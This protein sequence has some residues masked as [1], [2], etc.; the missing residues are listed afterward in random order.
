MA[1]PSRRLDV[2][3]TPRGGNSLRYW[4]SAKNP[5]G[6]AYNFLLIQASR[7]VPSLRL[8]RFLLRL[9]GMK[10]GRGAAIGQMATFDFFFPEKI[11]LGEDCIIGFGATILAHEFLM[12]E[13]RTGSTTVGRGALV[14]ANSTVLAGVSIG[15]GA[16]VSAMTL[17]NR[18]VPNGY[19]AQGVP[20]RLQKKRAGRH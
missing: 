11:S 4:T 17:V 15:D 20:C 10:V 9:T 7:I 3:K 1:A 2:V 8:K 5:A 19:F 6:V 12:N 16:V 14:G 18:D 13:Y